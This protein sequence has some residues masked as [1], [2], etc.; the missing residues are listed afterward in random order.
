MKTE[1]VTLQT[2]ENINDQAEYY[3]ACLILRSLTEFNL[4]HEPCKLV[5]PTIFRHTV[6]D[7]CLVPHDEYTDYYSTVYIEATKSSSPNDRKYQ[8]KRIA[9]D[10]LRENPNAAYLQLFYP[11]YREQPQY[12]LSLIEQLA[13]R[14]LTSEQ[15]QHQVY[16]YLENPHLGNQ[17]QQVHFIY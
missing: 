15:A 12:A 6:P 17:Q 16:Q 14:S 2:I 3:L 13:Y 1:L 7:F 8:Q 5:G 4:Y 10:W 11:F 9:Y